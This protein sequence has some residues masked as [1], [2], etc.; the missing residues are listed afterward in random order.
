VQECGK[1]ALECG[2]ARSKMIMVIMPRGKM[3]MRS[4]STGGKVIKM[5]T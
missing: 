5:I 2:L 3:I 4:P 1:A